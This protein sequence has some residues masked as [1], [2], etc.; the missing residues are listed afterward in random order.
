MAFISGKQ[1]MVEPTG[2]HIPFSSGAGSV[3]KQQIVGCA[4]MDGVIF[5]VRRIF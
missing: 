3:E 2:D 1:I 5:P 4:I